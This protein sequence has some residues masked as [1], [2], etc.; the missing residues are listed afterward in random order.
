MVPWSSLGSRL[1]RS[2]VVFTSIGHKQR[3]RPGGDAAKA[4]ATTEPA[5]RRAGTIGDVLAPITLPRHFHESR[6]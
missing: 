5:T 4:M 6:R 2:R 3:Q 1:T